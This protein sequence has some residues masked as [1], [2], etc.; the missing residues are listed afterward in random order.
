MAF[1]SRIMSEGDDLDP[2]AGLLQ[3]LVAQTTQASCGPPG[4][5]RVSRSGG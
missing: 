1:R 5:R 3:L 4:K 2:E